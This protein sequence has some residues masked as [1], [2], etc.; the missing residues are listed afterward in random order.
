M[1]FIYPCMYWIQ[2]KT[3]AIF[4]LVIARA[5]L[6][7]VLNLIASDILENIS[8]LHFK[9]PA[10][11]WYLDVFVWKKRS[12]GACLCLLV[13]SLSSVIERIN[14]EVVSK[15]PNNSA[16]ATSQDFVNAHVSL[17]V[18]P[19]FYS[20]NRPYLL[21]SIIFFLY[22][23][24]QSTVHPLSAYSCSATGVIFLSGMSFQE[25]GKIPWLPICNWNIVRVCNI[26]SIESGE[27]RFA[28]TL[29]GQRDHLMS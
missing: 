7:E 10:K 12:L 26:H 4:L 14:L 27:A 6:E 16:F 5:S 17:L 3:K 29:Q 13:L 28:Q 8:C 18:L 25:I 1:R 9:K 20:L 2:W 19:C 23:S 11:T 15:T 22:S 24:Y 21:L